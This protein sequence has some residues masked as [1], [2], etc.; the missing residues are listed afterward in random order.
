VAKLAAKY[1]RLTFCYEAGPTGYGLYRLI[2]GLGHD[3]TVAAPSLIPKK[4]GERVKT[5]RRDGVSLARL[6]RAGELTAVWVPDER[7]EAMRD[8]SRAR[9][10]AHKDLRGK[11]QQISSM[12]L[13]LGRHYPGKKT[14][15]PAHMNWLMAQKL[16]HRE[17]RIAF[18]ELMAG[19]RQESERVERLEQAIRDAVP[20]WSLAEVVTALQAMRGIDLIAAVAVLA[21]IGDLSRFRNPRE[22]MGYLGLVPSESSTGDTVKRGG[23]TKAGNGRARRVLVESAWSYRHPPRVSRE[24][25][26]KVAAAPKAAREI[27]WKAQVRLCRRYRSLERKGKLRTVIATAIAREL[28]AFIWAINCEVMAGRRDNAARGCGPLESCSAQ[29]AAPAL[30]KLRS[31]IVPTTAAQPLQGG[32]TLVDTPC[33]V[34]RVFACFPNDSFREQCRGPCAQAR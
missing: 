29:P 23:I 34:P 11:R 22:L 24:K 18:E 19:I 25:Q 17:Q 4:P 10:A 13:R 7:H 30:A 28:S 31:C 26:A 2:R 33:A 6:L 9:L 20:E 3:C 16:E 27:A 5:N 8:L 12:M 14:W 21:E 1:D 15:G 32:S